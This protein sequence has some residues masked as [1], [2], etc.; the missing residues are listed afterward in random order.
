MIDALVIGAGQSGL[1]ATRALL[2]HGLAP[3]VLEAGPE[4]VGSWPHYYDSLTLFSPAQHSA[5]PGLEFPA[6]PDH[7][8]RRDEV[9]AYLRHYAAT[10]DVDIRTNTAVTRVETHPDTG[11]L[12]HTSTGETLHTA[13]I[14]AATGSFGNPHMPELPGQHTY[15]GTLLHAADYR[16]PKPYAGQ[17]IIV[18][19]AG[20]SAVQIAHELA[21]VAT[22]TLATHHPI[23]FLAQHRDGRDIHHWLVTTGFDLLPPEWLIRYVGG[24]LVLDI[25]TYQHA[26]TAGHLDRRPVFTSLDTETITWPN[27][28]R[29]PVDTIIFATGYR[30]D[31]AYL[32]PLGALHDGYP[33]HSTGISTTH[34]GLVY[35]G[36][37]FQR[38]FSSNTLRGV[39]HD[40]QHIITALAAHVHGAPTAV[41]L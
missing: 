9:T 29:E 7:Y 32:E 25:G 31:L 35:L 26:L 27:G 19:G 15:T 38:S 40:A 12:V 36:L 8:P 13:G 2:D 11:F 3:V 22:V 21:E 10:L 5:L 17:R 39:H 16:N 34:P 23:N 41:G 1:A 30:P 37:E 6:E 18:V 4:P 14:V 20:N 28:T 24:T 33:L